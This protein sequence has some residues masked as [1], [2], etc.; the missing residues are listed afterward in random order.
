MKLFLKKVL[1]LFWCKTVLAYL[2]GGISSIVGLHL[3]DTTIDS[4][5]WLLRVAGCN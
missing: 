1:G 4:I 3:T 2:L 5:V